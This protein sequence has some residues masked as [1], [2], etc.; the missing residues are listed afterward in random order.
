MNDN[1]REKVVTELVKNDDIM[2]YW[3]M[4]TLKLDAEKEGV[5]RRLVV[6]HWVT[7]RGFSF[8]GAYIE[9]YKQCTKK[10]LQ[11]SKGLRTK[12]CNK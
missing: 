1:F 9:M 7:V 11:R 8:A 6:E 3:C 5:L 10:N 2:F 4:L 12:L